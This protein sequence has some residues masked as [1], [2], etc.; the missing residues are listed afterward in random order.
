M[1]YPADH[2]LGSRRN[3]VNHVG[4]EMPFWTQGKTDPERTK[5]YP[6]TS[7]TLL[8]WYANTMGMRS[9]RV[10]F[11]WEAVQ[12]NP[13]P[14]P[15]PPFVPN[16]MGDIDPATKTGGY[17][18]YW[19]DLVKLVIGF[20]DRG[21]YV[22]L[23]PWQYRPPSASTPGDTDITYRGQV[24]EPEHFADFWGKFATAINN[25]VAAG[26]PLDPSAKFPTD[27]TRQRKLA[28]D[29]INEPHEG[30]GG[31][32]GIT[33]TKWKTC[34]QRAID[35]IRANPVNANT[36]FVEGMSYAS[37]HLDKHHLDPIH[38]L[39]ETLSD[40]LNNI[41]ISAHCYDGTRILPGEAAVEK[42]FDALR[43][44]CKDLLDWARPRGLKVHIGE[45]AVDAGF[46]GCSDLPHAQSKW[47][48]WSKFCLESDDVLVGWNWW[49][50]TSKNW[51]WSDEGSCKAGQPNIEGGRNW[52][53]THDDGATY[54]VHADLIKASI[55]V[56]DL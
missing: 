12:K 38:I 48:D 54:T 4:M 3:G 22:T 23:C 10:V 7:P 50:N 14:L 45:V 6:V 21:V 32:V 31:V 39:W 5:T 36:I 19:D 17:K 51:G 9:A 16:V 37:A 27:A 35:A 47:D 40:P 46:G 20:I 41:A 34:T 24:F 56:S 2:V 44:A 42:P 52:A 49:A 25:N 8:D 15:A 18:D 30:G 55:P 28:F 29:L 1:W 33:I 43:T 53:L 11:S 26:F 13:D